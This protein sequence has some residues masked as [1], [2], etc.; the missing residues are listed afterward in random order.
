MR[1]W[2]NKTASKRLIKLG[3]RVDKAQN[4]WQ[5]QALPLGN[6][7]LGITVTGEPYNESVVVN[8]K[9]LWTGG[10]SPKRPNYNGGNLNKTKDGLDMKEVFASAREQLKRGENAD[11]ICK[12]LVGDTNG[13]GSYQC[14]GVWRIR[15][16]NRKVENYSFALD[17]DKAEAIAIWRKSSE[18][19]ARN[20]FVSYPDKVAV[21]EQTSAVPC[22]WELTW[23][24]RVDGAERCNLDKTSMLMQ[25]QLKDNALKYVMSCRLVCNG[26]VVATDKG[27]KVQSATKTALI[28][29]YKTDYSDNYPTYR[30]GKSDVE[31]KEEVL[32][33]TDN[34]VRMGVEKLRENHV[35]DWKAL[36]ASM[37]FSLGASEPQI[38]TDKLLRNYI[39]S[40]EKDKRWIE[41]LLFAYGR[42]LMISSSRKDDVLPNNLQGIWNCSDSPAWASDYHLN[43]NLQMNY[44]M[45]PL[46]GLI[47]C[48]M[49][50]IRYLQ[51]LRAPGRVT[52]STYCGIGDGKSESG[53]LYHTQNTPFGWTCPGWEFC[54]GWSAV[55]PAW[56]LHNVYETYLFSANKQLLEEIYPMLKEATLTYDALMDKSG[57]RWLISPSFSPEHGP[58]T[59][60]N[61]FDQIFIW[62]LYSDAI[63]AG[64]KLG[65]DEE[66]IEEWK[67]VL[68]KLKPIE[69]GVDNQILEWYHEKQLGS[70]G[71]KHHRHVSH[72][73]GLYP[74]A[75]IGKNDSE[76]LQATKVSLEDR[77]GKST[78][79]ATAL[80]LCLWARL[81]DGERAYKLVERLINNNI[82]QNLWD[83]HPP[84]QIDGNF[85]YV[86]GVCEMLVHSHGNA[87]KLLPTLPNEWSEGSVRGLCVRG[88]FAID[89]SWKKCN[90]KEISVHTLT[91]GEFR[92]EVVQDVKVTDGNVIEVE[93]VRDGNIVSWHC[94]KGHVYR[95]CKKKF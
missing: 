30:S 93:V 9:T 62:Q 59:H 70:V 58:I 81:Y 80:R 86:A 67:E 94:E 19:F 47:D 85:G 64:S 37:E 25:G 71:E 17:F 69:V 15:S 11:E 29:T 76:L 91:E 95:V 22:D 84:F 8:E 36:Y 66:K 12:K 82:Y 63:D 54:W 5:Q 41:Q 79:W 1:I 45:A 55:A 39:R 92:L 53:Y 50:L 61:T 31:M 57:E 35:K 6:G 78:G 23:E 72:L 89:F 18:R 51:A 27:W 3:Q 14:A 20:A 75:L 43:I 38:P 2:Y 44:W 40:N 49:P 34:A 48:E 10:P 60:G 33:L 74:C 21:I 16:K 73:M 56:I 32:E 13:Y 88:G 90:W 87:V 4:R 24:S 28:F 46:T 42:Y 68:S 65:E 83:T 52:A 77:G 26:V 7:M